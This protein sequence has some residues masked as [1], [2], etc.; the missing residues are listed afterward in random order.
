MT[1]R[2]TESGFWIFLAIPDPKVHTIGLI[3]IL[4][5]T[6]QDLFTISITADS[7]GQGKKTKRGRDQECQTE[8]LI[9]EEKET[10]TLQATESVEVQADENEADQLVY[11]NGE[12]YNEEEL[13]GFLRTRFRYINSTLKEYAILQSSKCTRL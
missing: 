3:K 2:P 4:M 5:F 1:V 12:Q 7:G 8:E 10:T 9:Y 13:E 11:L 6:D